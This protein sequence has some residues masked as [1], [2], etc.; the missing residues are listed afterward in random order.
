[1]GMKTSVIHQ[2]IIPEY[3]IYL[4]ISPIQEVNRESIKDKG[5]S[6]EEHSP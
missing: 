1:M 6:K 5:M 4:D 3:K 2:W